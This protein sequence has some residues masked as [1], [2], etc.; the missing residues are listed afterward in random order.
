MDSPKPVN[1][2]NAN[3]PR[4]PLP[5]RERRSDEPPRSMSAAPWLMLLGLV[6]LALLWFSLKGPGNTGTRVQLL[7]L[8]H[9]SRRRKCKKHKGL[10]RDRQRQMEEDSAQSPGRRRQADRRIQRRSPP[11]RFDRTQL[12]GLNPQ[13]GGRGRRRAARAELRA[14]DHLLAHRFGGADLLFDL[15]DAAECGSPGGRNDGELH[16][17]P[18]Q[19]VPTF[20]PAN[21]LPRCGRSRA[22]E[23]RVAGDRR[24]PQESRQI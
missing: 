13:Q 8:S 14:A 3:P 17:Q 4:R 15:H 5:R 12:L 18:G 21:N 7:L 6:T 23:A 10:W 11:R 24:V 2:P 19:A 20:G 22:G 16:P 1:Q 9:G